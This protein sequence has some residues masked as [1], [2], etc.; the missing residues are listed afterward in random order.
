MPPRTSRVDTLSTGLDDTAGGNNVRQRGLNLVVTHR[1]TPTG[2]LSIT[3][4]VVKGSETAGRRTDLRSFSTYWSDK[5][6][7]RTNFSLGV[8]H[9]EYDA[10]VDPYNE[11][12]VIANLSL[13]F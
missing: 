13:R 9:T 7:M 2:A 1:L 6:S 5:L 11:N 10:D 4:S 12:A 3:T 8:R